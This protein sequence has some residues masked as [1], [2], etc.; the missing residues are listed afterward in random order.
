[1]IQIAIIDYDIGNVKSIINALEKVGATIVVTRNKKDIFNSDGVVLP[2]VGAFSH[3]MKKLNDYNL[4]KTII[5]FV[6]QK[7]PLL[8]ICLGMQMLFS[9]SEEF[10]T[11]KGL[12]LI[13]GK[14]KKLKTLNPKIEKLPH[15]S[16]NEILQPP[17]VTWKNTILEGL[18]SSSNMFFVHTYAAQPDNQENILSITEYSNF[19]FCSTVQKENI[20]G[21]QFHPEKS[22]I[23][24]L[25]IMN[26]FVN[27]CKEFQNG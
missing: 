12:D 18:N 17:N 3:G 16:W 19:Q 22:A 15:V 2:G 6:K 14:I 8:G 24:G 20:Y 1:M 21:C 25:L 26:N 4:D 7:K 10:G 9:E 23:E 5:Q 13:G 11:C 27:I